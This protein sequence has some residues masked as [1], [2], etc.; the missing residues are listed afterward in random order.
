MMQWLVGAT[1]TASCSNSGTVYTCPLTEANG[2][3]ALIVWNTTGNSSYKPA[4]QYVD[5]RKFNG[6][7]GGATQS[8][9]AGQAATIGVI[10]I[11]FET[12]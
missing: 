11:M 12:N 1:F 7:Y 8:I 6:T 4:S 5:Y 9:S 10:P 2:N 3:S